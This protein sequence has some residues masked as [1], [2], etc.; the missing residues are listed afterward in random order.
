VEDTS[1]RQKGGMEG[2]WKLH[3]SRKDKDTAERRELPQTN[4]TQTTVEVCL[5][6]DVV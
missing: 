2:G 3:L 4:T 5:I 6:T 1:F